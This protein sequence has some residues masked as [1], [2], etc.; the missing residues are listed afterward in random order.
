MRCES[1]GLEKARRRTRLPVQFIGEAC[2]SIRT[3]GP[4]TV[5]P[6]RVQ[7]ACPSPLGRS[8]SNKTNTY[9]V[10]HIQ[11]GMFN[12]KSRTMQAKEKT[13]LGTLVYSRGNFPKSRIHRLYAGTP[14][15]RTS[16]GIPLRTQSGTLAAT[17][18]CTASP[19]CAAH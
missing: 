3:I 10:L 9:R 17:H 18:R 8:S 15:R 2:M 16:A 12:I 4:K 5:G 14:H 11:H 7:P 19:L 1:V 13:E 6:L